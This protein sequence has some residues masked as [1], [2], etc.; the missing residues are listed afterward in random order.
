[1][2]SLRKLKQGSK[3]S[4]QVY[5]ISKDLLERGDAQT[6]QAVGRYF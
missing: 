4:S 6:S 5:I 1:M 2:T 3:A